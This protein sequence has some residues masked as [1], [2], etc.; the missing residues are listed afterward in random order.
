MEETILNASAR[1][2]QSGRF[3]EKGFVPGV[4]YGDTIAE[5]DSVKFETIALNK[6]IAKHGANAKVWINYNDSKKFGFIKEVQR[7]NVSGRIRHIDVQIVS[8]GRVMEL[9]IPVIFKGEDGLAR[10]GLQL[11]VYK[12]EV[13][14]SGTMDLMPDSITVDVSN[15]QLGDSITSINLALDKQLKVLEPENTVYGVIIN[16]PVD[17]TA[18]PEPEPA[19]E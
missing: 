10:T 17:A 9:D 16:Q 12:A 4:I 3:R 1:P 8:K 2:K 13:A 11:Q 5:A 6:V 7:D 14:V 15:M 18:E 19:G